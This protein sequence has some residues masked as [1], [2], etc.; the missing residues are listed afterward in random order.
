MAKNKQLALGNIPNTFLYRF[1]GLGIV[2]NFCRFRYGIHVKKDKDV[3]KIKGPLVCVGNHPSYLDPIVMAG[4]LLGRKINFVAGAFLFRDRIIGPIF[5]AGGCIPKMQFRSDSRAVKAM[6]TIL[7]KGGT[8]GIFPEATRF[9]DGSSIYFDDAIARMIKKTNSS[10]AFLESHGAYLTWPRW[11]TSSFRR[12]H[13]EGRIKRV[14]TAEQV[15]EMSLPELHAI[16]LE[17]MTYNEYDWAREHSYKYSNRAIAQGSENIAHACPRCGKSLVM[18]SH[19]D[20]LFCSACDN[21]IQMDKM[22]FLHPVTQQDKAFQD[23][24]EW[25]SWEYEE[26]DK[27]ISDPDFFLE[28]KVRLFLPRGEYEY[29]E[30]GSGLLRMEKGQIIYTGTECAIEDGIYYTKKELKKA[31]KGGFSMEKKLE[32]LRN[33]PQIRKV[34]QVS[35]IRGIG[36]E[37]G[38]RLELIENGEQIN[39]FVPENGQRVFE[40]QSAIRCMQKME[41]QQVET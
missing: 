2:L 32:E 10:V 11:S 30:V 29:R 25:I 26:M 17:N 36:A 21:Q 14:I 35:R 27:R 22:G 23:L 7:K 9:V 40:I 20:R 39:R 41:K 18:R 31:K 33:G 3:C 1:V 15:S 8:L 34:F 38:K 13:I 24:H 6:L 37:Y 12:G 16:M 28:E 5:A 4:V 19:G